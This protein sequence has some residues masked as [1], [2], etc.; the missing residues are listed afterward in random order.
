M[1]LMMVASIFALTSCGDDDDAEPAPTMNLYE[2]VSAESD[3]TKLKAYIDA[4]AT[5]KAKLEGSTEY[6][7]FAPNDAAFT[8]L[9]AILGTSLDQVA[10]SVVSQVLLFHFAKGAKTQAELTG[11][12]IATDQGENVV[13][14][15]GGN[16]TTGGSDTEVKILDADN[17]A[18]NGIMHKVET[19]LIPPTIFA[20]IGVNL[21]KLSQPILLGASFTTLA[22]AIA[23]A[24]T[25]ASAESKPTITSILAGDDPYTVF[26]PSNGTFEAASITL[27]AFTAEQWYGI[28]ANH[29]IVGDKA[30]AD[31]K[32]G[33]AYTSLAGGTLT[34]L[35]LNA[36]TDPDK[37][38]TTGI[39]IDSTG[40]ATPE[41]QVAVGDAFEGSNGRLHVIA[42]ILKPAP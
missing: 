11:G 25:Y 31:I 13:V 16:I 20:S 12:S 38:I 35:T 19:I 41:A 6:T 29:V 40:D 9:E 8:K 23:K 26:A 3:L 30:G 17:R 28:I 14:D 22:S 18:T 27:D 15:A 5:L 1:A 24:D 34:V 2:T 32:A 7:F 39:A 42:G 10:P 4:D 21:G 33:D 36:P 37:G